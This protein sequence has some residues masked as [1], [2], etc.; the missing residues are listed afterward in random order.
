MSFATRER[1]TRRLSQLT[2]AL[3]RLERD[4]YGRCTVCGQRIEP[5]RLVAIP[6]AATCLACQERQERHGSVSAVW[7]A[8]S[9][10]D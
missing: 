6:E 5:E 10:D 9:S 1:L 8:T 3:E 2:A 4:D 7:P